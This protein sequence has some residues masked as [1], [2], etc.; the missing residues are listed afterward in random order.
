MSRLDIDNPGRDGENPP[1]W[2]PIFSHQPKP[3]SRAEAEGGSSWVPTWRRPRSFGSAAAA[4]KPSGSPD[5]RIIFASWSKDWTPR[6]PRSSGRTRWA[7]VRGAPYARDPH[8]RD[9]L[10]AR[11]GP[12]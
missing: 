11:P 7:Y 8:G 5:G 6:G 2:R 4:A 1:R 9:I 12:S 10:A 3:G